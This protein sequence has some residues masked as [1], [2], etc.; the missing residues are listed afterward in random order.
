ML[1]AVLGLFVAAVLNMATVGL[2]DG[3]A[4]AV[5]ATCQSASGVVQD[6]YGNPIAGATVDTRPSD[7]S[8]PVAT[9]NSSGHY[10]VQIQPSVSGTFAEVSAPRYASSST[11]ISLVTASGSNTTQ[12]AYDVQVSASRWVQPGGTID[13]S[14]RTGAPPVDPSSAYACAFGQG[15]G[16]AKELASPVPGMGGTG[17]LSGLKQAVAMGDDMVALRTDGTVLTWALGD[18]EPTEVAGVGDTGYLST[19]VSVAAS[20]GDGSGSF[21]LALLSDGTVVAWGSNAQGELGTGS[22]GY[23]GTVST[24][25]TAVV[26]VGGTGT[27]SDVTAIAA[28]G[29]S[30]YALRSD[31]SVVAWGA[32]D[33]GQLGNADDGTGSYPYPEP[34]T[35]PQGSGELIAS[36]IAAGGDFAMALS[37]TGTVWTW[38]GDSKGELGDNSAPAASSIPVEVIGPGNS[39][40]LT[41]ITDIAAGG[42][43]WGLSQNDNSFAVAVGSN[44]SAYSWGD[45]S[46]GQLGDG[47][48]S[49]TSAYAA[50]PQTVELSG[51]SGLATQALSGVKSVVADGNGYSAYAILANGEAVGWGDDSYGELG[52]GNSSTSP[53][54]SAAYIEDATGSGPMTGVL[55]ADSTDSFG[56][57]LRTS[58]CPTLTPATYVTGQTSGTENTSINL[59]AGQ[60]DASGY[61]TWTGTYQV[62]SGTTDG[63]YSLDFCVLDAAYVGH[64]GSG[65]AP[66]AQVGEAAVQYGVDSTPPSAVSSTP[67]PYG[68]QQAVQTISV[69]WADNLSGVNPQTFKMTLDGSPVTVTASGTTETASL[70]NGTLTTGI[71]VVTTSAQDNSNPPNTGTDTFDFAITQVVDSAS[72]A[73]LDCS[74]GPPP[75][76]AEITASG[77]SASYTGSTSNLTG[78]T[79]TFTNVPVTVGSF[80]E[81]LAASAR[82]GYGQ[83]GRPYSISGIPVVFTLWA[84][85]NTNTN[86]SASAGSPSG[87][88]AVQTCDDYSPTGYSTSTPNET[89]THALA[90]LAPSAGSLMASIDGTS[91]TTIP[92][93]VASVPST[94]TA[95]T[96]FAVTASLGT[97]SGQL[98]PAS[99]SAADF[100]NDLDGSIPV[101]A[102]VHICATTTG[103]CTST[104]TYDSARAYIG[105]Q[106]IPVAAAVSAPSE[107]DTSY[108]SED[109]GC[110]PLDG[111]VAC[112]QQTTAGSACQFGHSAAGSAF[113]YGPAPTSC[114][115]SNYAVV[116]T[117]GQDAAPAQAGAGCNQLVPATDTRVDLCD[118]GA[119]S[120]GSY[121]GLY[122]S[123]F[124]Y[125]VPGCTTATTANCDS[126]LASADPAGFVLWQQDHATLASANAPAQCPDGIKGSVTSSLTN[127]VG[128]YESES[129]SYTP[130]LVATT[131][132]VD[133]SQESQLLDQQGSWGAELGDITTTGDQQSLETGS[134]GFQVSNPID[135]SDDPPAGSY[136]ESQLD[137]SGVAGQGLV[138]DDLA[139]T[140][141]WPATGGAA[142]YFGPADSDL[143]MWSGALF[144]ESQPGIS[145]LI[146]TEVSAQFN[147]D[148][149]CSA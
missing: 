85:T 23:D 118:V 148:Y 98:G 134:T 79:I 107:P 110:N 22:V 102:Q 143:E 83:V 50:T 47:Q 106:W 27:L 53:E 82:A 80:S 124:A 58:P 77:C 113:P 61:T 100:G 139:A 14:V 103:T 7:C 36:S 89:A 35:G 147:I 108:A 112:G 60:S 74:G 24:V 121:L 73:A 5:G 13:I 28:G 136:Y 32:D 93:I 25:P 144:A 54:Y 114:G 63:L 141:F 19:V 18:S 138:V 12:L 15:S 122:E 70:A 72:Q 34:V 3:S 45:N 92:Q 116:V 104:A 31:G 55:T 97:A 81:Q 115:L 59:I 4:Y 142:T 9:T 78:Q 65:Q 125:S 62:P 135:P 131:D 127:L 29:A 64:C 126:A 67:S 84:R 20:E 119:N 21:A 94:C 38:G 6:L 90:V 87:W 71:H 86:A 101:Q 17:A 111:Q 91:S 56:L 33:L 129:P 95:A 146:D 1:L 120:G 16:S 41:G 130:K 37:P 99:A 11:D 2:V 88:T 42:D 68:N 46:S 49:T 149:S 109:P 51:P 44:G 57:L 66:P 40:F 117:P 43:Y 26:G 133:G 96:G 39:G 145:P 140:S 75:S 10:T 132:R 123:L 105:D 8:Q 69:V 30:G 137:E 52:N 76:P 48:T 128:N